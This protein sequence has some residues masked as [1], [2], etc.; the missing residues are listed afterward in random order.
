MGKEKQ[1]NVKVNKVLAE[2]RNAHLAW[3]GIPVILVLMAP[4]IYLNIRDGLGSG[5]FQVH[6]QLD[7]T[8]LSYVFSARYWGYDV[9]SQMM[10]GVPSAGLKPSAILFVQLLSMAHIFVLKNLAMTAL[11]R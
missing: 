7:E 10:C 11:R 4:I 3:L 5:I 6:D 9:Y 8:I 2:L 1:I